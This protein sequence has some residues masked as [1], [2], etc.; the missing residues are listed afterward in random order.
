MELSKFYSRN[1]MFECND[2]KIPYLPMP[3]QIII[4]YTLSPG[5]FKKIY[6]RF[7][8]KESSPFSCPL[9]G[10]TGIADDLTTSHPAQGCFPTEMRLM[11]SARHILCVTLG[12][13]E[14]ICVSPQLYALNILRQSSMILKYVGIKS[15]RAYFVEFYVL[16]II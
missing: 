11:C 1:Y 14:S 7:F 6:E 13:V 2:L 9:L 16:N 4:L 5:A 8:E 12:C 3:P 15:M 10:E